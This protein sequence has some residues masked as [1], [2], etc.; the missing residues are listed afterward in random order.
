VTESFND[1]TLVAVVDAA[2]TQD[3]PASVSSWAASKELFA[4]LDVVLAAGNNGAGV[5][6]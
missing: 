2:S 1:P 4:L 5:A 6:E 3:L